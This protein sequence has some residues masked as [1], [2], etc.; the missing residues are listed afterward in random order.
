MQAAGGT[1]YPFRAR[2][3]REDEHW[4]SLAQAV[5]TF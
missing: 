5:I 1:D 3:D 4:L 2:I